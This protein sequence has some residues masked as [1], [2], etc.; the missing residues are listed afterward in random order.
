MSL[1]RLVTDAADVDRHAIL[2][3]A[4][5]RVVL[6]LSMHLLITYTRVHSTGVLVVHT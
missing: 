1:V 3:V 6:T 4:H 2:S 5:R